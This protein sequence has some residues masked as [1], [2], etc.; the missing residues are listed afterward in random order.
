MGGP[1]LCLG[2]SGPCVYDPTCEYQ[3]T[4]IKRFKPTG[5]VSCWSWQLSHGGGR[6]EGLVGRRKEQK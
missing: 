5:T 3:P 6:K 4:P 1:G 2:V